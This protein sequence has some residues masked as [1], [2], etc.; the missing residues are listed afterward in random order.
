MTPPPAATPSP[1]AICSACERGR[2]VIVE[3][4]ADFEG[5]RVTILPAPC[6]HCGSDRP[7]ELLAI[8]NLVRPGWRPDH[9]RLTTRAEQDLAREPGQ[10][11][12]SGS[13]F[14]VGQVRPE[15][16]G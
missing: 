16:D 13:T 3:T 5:G 11:S 4:R 9:H 15:G 7:P 12:Q 8:P 10:R 2:R 1:N 14:G 6:P